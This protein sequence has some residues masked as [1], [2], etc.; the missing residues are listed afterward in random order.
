MKELIKSTTTPAV[1]MTQLSNEQRELLPLAFGQ[2]LD[3]AATATS[4]ATYYNTRAE[5]ESAI[6]SV[7]GELFELDRGVYA[8]S[9]MLPG[10]TDFSRQIG[11]VR[12][13]RS[14]QTSDGWL[15]TPQEATIIRGLLRALPPQRMLK[16]FGMLRKERV[17]NSRTF[18]DQIN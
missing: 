13:L 2:F 9:L 1:R 14:A 4:R 8:A 6:E 15:T 17:N 16:M 3:T 7:H 11:A 18:G 5:Q 12:L 10:L